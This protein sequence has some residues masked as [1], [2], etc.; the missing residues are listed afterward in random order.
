MGLCMAVV[1]LQAHLRP[2]KRSIKV[3][4]TCSISAEVFQWP[5]ERYERAR[6]V[7]PLET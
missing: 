6:L 7:F 1:T 4:M 2:P 5:V 3:E